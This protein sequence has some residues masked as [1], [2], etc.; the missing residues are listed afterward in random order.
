MSENRELLQ[1]LYAAFN[2]R[3]IETVLSMM[4][5]DVKWANGMEGSFVHGRDA[6]REYW[7]NQFELVDPQLEL[8]KFEIDGKGRSVVNVHQIVQDLN[9]NVLLD[10]T[11][12][13]IFTFENGLIK[14]FEI[15]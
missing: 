8:L 2:K 10:K 6:V 3:E 11:V 5:E 13:Q 14:T 9:G 1:Y 12:K 15:G 7:K 4:R